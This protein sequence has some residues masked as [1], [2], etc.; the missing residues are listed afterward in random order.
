MHET[1][2]HTVSADNIIM[3]HI[4]CCPTFLLHPRGPHGENQFS[5]SSQSRIAHKILEKTSQRV[6]FEKMN[7]LKL[8]KVKFFGV[9]SASVGVEVELDYELEIWFTFFV[10]SF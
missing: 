10:G 1:Q 4:M 8:E 9:F 5:A 7:C 6:L 3:T 2:A